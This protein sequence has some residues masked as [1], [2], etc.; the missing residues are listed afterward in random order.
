MTDETDSDSLSLQGS[1][2]SETSTLASASSIYSPHRTSL[3]T[4]PSSVGSA[5]VS[6]RSSSDT[7]LI[8]PFISDSNGDVRHE[9][10]QEIN[11]EV[12]PADVLTIRQACRYDC[13]CLCHTL[14]RAKDNP[15]LRELK[16][17]CTEPGC[18]GAGLLQDESPIPSFFR[19]AISAVVSSRSIKIRYH[20]STYRMVSEGSDALRYVKHGNLEKLKMC[21]QT[22][23][24]TLW[25]TA[26]DGWSL[27]HVSLNRQN[28]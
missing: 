23:E 7:S 17:N 2:Q 5:A 28:C 13:F 22:G 26:P 24:A 10:F 14:S 8:S 1:I 6:L 16:N 19:K 9:R 4:A 27:L 11:G 21:I 15:K 25:D 3:D 18:L 12:L 20:L